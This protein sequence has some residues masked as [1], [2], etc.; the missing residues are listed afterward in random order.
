MLITLISL[1]W[2]ATYF[3]YGYPVWAAIWPCTS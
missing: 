2:V 1:I 3:A